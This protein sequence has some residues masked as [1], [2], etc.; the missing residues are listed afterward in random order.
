MRRGRRLGGVVATLAAAWGLAQVDHALALPDLWTVASAFSGR[1]AA[2]DTAT[3]TVGRSRTPFN[4]VVNA[5]A[6][7]PT[8][9][10][11]YLGFL[12][13]GDGRVVRLDPY[14]LR[15]LRSTPY[16]GHGQWSMA[17]HPDGSR[18]Y[19][20]SID[21]GPIDVFDTETLA[22]IATIGSGTRAGIAISPDG[23]RLYA[24]YGTSVLVADTATNAIVTTVPIG[25]IGTWGLAVH[26]DGTR[27]YATDSFGFVQVIDTATNT[28]VD[29]VLVGLNPHGIAVHPDGTRV[30]VANTVSNTLT[31][32][33]ATTLAILADVPVGSGP[34]LPINDNSPSDVIA[35]PDGTRVYVTLGPD[36]TVAVLDTATDTITTEITVGVDINAFGQPI[37]GCRTLGD[38]DDDGLADASDLCPGVPDP[39]Q[40]DGDG[41]GVGDAC[42]N[43]PT[44]PNPEQLDVDNDG[45]GSC[46]ICGDGIAEFPERCDAG[47]TGDQCCSP[48]CEP[49]TGTPCDDGH[50]CTTGD[51]CGS[52]GG[53]G[54]FLVE[55]LV[56]DQCN[57]ANGLCESV[58]RPACKL[59]PEPHR[60]RLTIRD[61][62]DDASD[63][64]VWK[65]M[66]GED[67][68]AFL[69]G[70]PFGAD[71][72]Y[73]L[74]VFDESGPTPNLVMRLNVPGQDACLNE[75]ACGWT[76]VYGG[77]KYLDKTA[78]FQGVLRAK[79]LDQRS[80][81]NVG[82]VK[83]RGAELPLPVLPLSTPL[84]VQLQGEQEC[85]EG[86]FD[87]A[88]VLESSTTAFRAKGTP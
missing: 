34:P 87:A 74:C 6:A 16:L 35:H 82:L 5:I 1:L 53:C 61:S 66:R 70:H 37:G 45:I 23:S 36:G 62:T 84:R 71:R 14:T 9:A 3:D 22:L 33:D 27:V 15:V 58:V 48:A 63:T 88:G 32:L 30:Y 21:N 50:L 65:W 51:V 69:L 31:V 54:G 13:L 75:G 83:G 18:L 78:G 44:R 39:G 80:R 17:V 10:R 26:P 47:P 24:G 52:R 46:P 57:P 67:Y 42:D 20:T 60:G 56:C 2:I 49:L 76:D 25:G 77:F 7:D 19:T 72:G 4:A 59:L 8:S 28:V 11:V 79:F 86:R 85:L 81:R 40:E 73:G 43:C 41:D 64:L 38:C 12:Y 29:G 68:D 55:C